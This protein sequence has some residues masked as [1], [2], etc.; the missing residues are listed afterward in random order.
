MRVALKR[1]QS[2]GV[3]HRARPRPCCVLAV[4]ARWWH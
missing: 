3:K 1:L 2:D 4:C